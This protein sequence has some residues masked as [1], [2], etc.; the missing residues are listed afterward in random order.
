MT[1]FH[2]SVEVGMALLAMLVTSWNVMI[3]S[4]M[5]ASLNLINPDGIAVLALSWTTTIYGSLE[6]RYPS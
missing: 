5:N 3:S 6:V 4:A 2:L 1:D